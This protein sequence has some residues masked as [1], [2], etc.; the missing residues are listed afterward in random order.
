MIT[1]DFLQYGYCNY[2][3]MTWYTMSR[4]WQGSSLLEGEIYAKVEKAICNAFSLS[5]FAGGEGVGSFEI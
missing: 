4:L 5:R 3:P 1:K 2:I